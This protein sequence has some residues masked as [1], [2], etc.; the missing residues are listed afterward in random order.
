MSI[1]QAKAFFEKLQNDEDLQKQS[2]ITFL[3]WRQCPDH[4]TRI[5][6]RQF[7]S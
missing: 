7:A 4:K 6:Y 3:C 1:E 2:G 5:L